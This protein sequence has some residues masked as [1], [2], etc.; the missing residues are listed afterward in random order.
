[1][2]VRSGKRRGRSIALL[3]VGVIGVVALVELAAEMT[4]WS[5]N[6]RAEDDLEEPLAVTRTG[7]GQK[8]LLFHG[9]RGSSSYWG[10]HLDE[11]ETTHE[12][13][14]IDL[15]GFGNSPWPDIEYTVNQHLDAIDAVVELRGNDKVVVVGHSAGATL[16][17]AW[18]AR[19]PG[20]V[21]RMVLLDLPLFD[22]EEEG[23][24]QIRQM[25]PLAAAF[26]LR[27]WLARGGCDLMCALRPVLWHVAP[28]LDRRVP[29]EVARNGVLH[30]WS[31]FDGTLRNVVLA[32]HARDYL[33]KLSGIPT[34]I[35]QG[36]QDEISDLDKLEQV[37]ESVGASFVRVP[38]GHNAYLEHPEVVA[39]IIIRA[40]N[41]SNGSGSQ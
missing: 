2:S 18:A 13:L 24:R 33:E 34:T 40:V 29:P 30:R 12:L 6:R 23:R 1:M 11:L 39:P 17:L 28:V 7:E 38:G 31:S 25:S 8:V 16:S 20:H 27:P 22:S 19:H 35:I 5:H 37:A 4:R 21:E 26:S 10:T 15:L 36:E 32:V 41:G 3:A 14:K 9:L